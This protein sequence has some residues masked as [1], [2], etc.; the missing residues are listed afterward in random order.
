MLGLVL[1]NVLMIVFVALVTWM[2]PAVLIGNTLIDLEWVCWSLNFFSETLLLASVFY[3]IKKLHYLYP[4]S[5]NAM[6]GE[7]IKMTKIAVVFGVA[8]L[9]QTVYVTALYIHY[10]QQKIQ[11]AYK[12]VE[13]SV[14]LLPI[15]ICELPIFTV[16]RMH[17]VNFDGTGS[18]DMQTTS[19]ESGSD[20]WDE[21]FLEE[22]QNSQCRTPAERRQRLV[23][24]T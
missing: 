1:F 7:I 12:M 11:I 20:Y 16:F 23:E 15:V 17:Q 4:S 10:R 3:S 21:S 8:F 5:E 9:V 13:T 14:T 24:T 22:S 19:R 2:Q 6:T 18:E